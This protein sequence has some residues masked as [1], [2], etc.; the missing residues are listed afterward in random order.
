[1]R[2]LLFL[3]LFT[4]S[5]GA[6]LKLSGAITDIS[7]SAGKAAVST[8]WGKVYLVDL[9]DFSVKADITVPDITDFTG[10]KQKGLQR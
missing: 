9:S 2:F 1:M 4:L 5:F 6:E 8:E 10:E 3:L 7:H